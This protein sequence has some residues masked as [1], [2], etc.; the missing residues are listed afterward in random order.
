VHVACSGTVVAEGR[1]TARQQQAQDKLNQAQQVIAEFAMCV[2]HTG[3]GPVLGQPGC[4][5]CTAST[6]GQ[7]QL[8][9][10]HSSGM[11]V[12][13]CLCLSADCAV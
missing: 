7:A 4:T 12:Q 3:D 2:A 8:Y 11:H 13:L 9:R 5:T 10:M 6:A 1:L